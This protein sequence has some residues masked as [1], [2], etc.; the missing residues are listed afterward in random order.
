MTIFVLKFYD[1]CAT[2]AYIEHLKW[3]SSHT[4]LAHNSWAA[5]LGGLMHNRL[6]SKKYGHYVTELAALTGLLRLHCCAAA[7]FATAGQ[8]NPCVLQAVGP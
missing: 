8:E 1:V 2:P 7:W 6:A 4:L 3:S 5:E